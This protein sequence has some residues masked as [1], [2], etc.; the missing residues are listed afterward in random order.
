MDLD[1]FPLTVAWFKKMKAAVP[2]YEKVNGELV[3][4]FKDFMKEKTDL[5]K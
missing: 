5:V 2:N 3:A 4:K 1:Q